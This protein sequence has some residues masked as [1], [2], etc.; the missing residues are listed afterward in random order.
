MPVL[1]PNSSQPVGITE[2]HFHRVLYG[3]G[4]R[5]I[6]RNAIACFPLGQNTSKLSKQCGAIVINNEMS[7]RA[8]DGIHLTGESKDDRPVTRLAE[9]PRMSASLMFP[10]QTLLHVD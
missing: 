1:F 9:K 2:H 5:D 3:L 10:V 4:G 8:R 6:V 7:Y